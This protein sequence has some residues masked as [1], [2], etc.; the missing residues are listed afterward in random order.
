MNEL[1]YKTN[2]EG[3]RE[4]MKVFEDLETIC[5]N[6]RKVTEDLLL[7]ILDDNKD[8]EYGK[9]YHF[10]QIHSLKDYKRMVPVITYEDIDEYMERVKKGEKNVLTTY[11]FK[12]INSTSG[13]VGKQKAV[14]LTDEQAAVYMKYSNRLNLGILCKELGESWMHG[15]SYCTSE[16]NYTTLDSGITYGCASSIM[17]EACKGGLEPYSSMLKS[18]YTS[19]PE[20][21]SPGPKINTKYM[22][23]R[24]ALMDKD[25]TGITSGFMSTIISHLQYIRESHKILIDDIEKGTISPYIEMPEETRQ[26][27]QKRIV[28]MPERAAELREIFK[29]GADFQF[30]PSVWPKLE[31][32]VA[33]GGDGFQ[34]YD[35]SF[36]SSY[37]GDR[38]HRLYGGVT[39]SE[40]LW[41]VPI[42]LD[43]RDSVIVPDSAVM[44]FQPV[45]Y[46]DDFSHIKDIDELEVGKI[47]ELVITNLCGFYRYRMSDAV[48]VV[49]FW[50]NTPLIQFMYRV[51]KTINIVCEKTTE[52]ALL[53]TAQNTAKKL[54][55]QLLD[56]E[57]Y[58]DKEVIP[59]KYVFLIEAP[60]DSPL[61][62]SKK[63]L[64]KVVLEELCKANVEF[65]E[66]Y[67]ENL[68][69]GPDC[70]FECPDTQLLHID[71]MVYKGASPSQA[72]PV[73]VISNEQQKQF[74]MVLRNKWKE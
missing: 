4:G 57:V 50:H 19:P 70:W 73:H 51:N 11:N 13:T 18:M 1:T 24:F 54:G 9:K 52:Q 45:E 41:S 58:P 66:C 5:D 20:A 14:P 30:V 71:K 36:K 60:D 53:V 65:E 64:D 55:F 37:A 39:A 61:K 2:F 38:I 34:V 44:E 17:A 23:T 46:E 25:L 68:I 22:H 27:L 59:P 67:N 7:K 33:V 28:P 6:P 48:K 35:E 40:G 62:I 56:Y 69:L 43:C 10:D 21:M 42:K 74:F 16:G 15:R 49:G 32:V 31:Y 12:H 8:T 26:S 29:N 72:K 3:A 47:Y 63:E